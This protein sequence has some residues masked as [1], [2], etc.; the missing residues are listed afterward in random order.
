MPVNRSAS[1]HYR[2][3]DGTVVT[4]TE[5]WGTRPRPLGLSGDYKT[6][7]ARTRRPDGTTTTERSD[8]HPFIA[9]FLFLGLAGMVLEGFNSADWYWVLTSAVVSLVVV[10]VLAAIVVHVIQCVA[11]Y[12]KRRRNYGA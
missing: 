3:P 1:R 2:Q 10:L 5:R 11:A 8:S 9:A 12:F 7:T 6:T 4:V